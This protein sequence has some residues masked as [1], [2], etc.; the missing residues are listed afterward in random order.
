M[1]AA[2]FLYMLEK[3]KI[4]GIEAFSRGLSVVT[5]EPMTKEARDALAKIGV[6]APPHNSRHLNEDAVKKADGL[7]TMTEAQTLQILQRFP[8]AKGKT[9][10]LASDDIADPMGGSPSDYEKCRI[11]IQ[12]ALSDLLTDLKSEGSSKT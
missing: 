5:P 2:L 12:N 10:R 8:D 9:R 4:G 11:D 7:F 6:P 1:A 3:E